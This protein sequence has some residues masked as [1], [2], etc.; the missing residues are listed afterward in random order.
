MKFRSLDSNWDWNF[1]GG[2]TSYSSDS[3]AIAYDIKSKILSWYGDCF[4]A[5]NEGIDWKNILGTK[6][7]KKTLDSNIKNIIINAFGVFDMPFFESFVENR[8]YHCTVKIKT[9]YN[10]TI[11]VKI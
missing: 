2:A 1:G 3:K 5:M 6:N 9:I 7:Q 8:V 4:F 10:E 11:E